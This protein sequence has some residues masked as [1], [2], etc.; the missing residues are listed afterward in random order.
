MN[1]RQL[2]YVC[3]I[4]KQDFNISAAA[5]ALNSS[6]P[7]IS[8][9]I[10]LLERELG[11]RIFLRTGNRLSGLTP[12]AKRIIKSAQKVV[13]EVSYIK[14]VCRAAEADSSGQLTIATI[15]THAR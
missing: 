15:P 11:T 5:I 10:K 2:Q 8:R 3:E 4:V 6:Q 9:Q 1:L 12:S 14:A 7:G 13:Q